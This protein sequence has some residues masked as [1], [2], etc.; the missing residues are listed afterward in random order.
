MDIAKTPN[1]KDSI[2][3]NGKEVFLQ[4]IS[5]TPFVVK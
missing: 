1:K 5:L 4:N 3:I 2:E